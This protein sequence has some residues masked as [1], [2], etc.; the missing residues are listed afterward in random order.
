[1][2]FLCASKCRL[3]SSSRVVSVCLDVIFISCFVSVHVGHQMCC[4]SLIV[5]VCLDIVATLV[6]KEDTENPFEGRTGGNAGGNWADFL[7]PAHEDDEV[8]AL[9]RCLLA[10]EFVCSLDIV[11]Y[12]FSCVFYVF[13]ARARAVCFSCSFYFCMFLSILLTLVSCVLGVVCACL[14]R[15]LELYLCSSVFTFGEHFI[16]RV[17]SCSQGYR[18][19]WRD[20]LPVVLRSAHVLKFFIRSLLR[21]SMRCVLLF[22]SVFVRVHSIVMYIHRHTIR[23][24]VCAYQYVLPS[25]CQC[26][27]FCHASVLCLVL[28]R[29]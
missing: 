3:C 13:Y 1:M 12:V 29:L 2:S 21:R 27:L 25:G 26:V 9:K 17:G 8:C 11:W 5:F 22:V 6:D 14:Y 18:D 28:F 20:P 15:A 19:L 24:F 4:P 7:D 23:I 16:S 10:D